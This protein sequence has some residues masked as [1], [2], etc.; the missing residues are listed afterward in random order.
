MAH[1][2]KENMK[3]RKIVYILGLFIFL[4]FLKIDFRITND[5]ICCNDDY[6]YFS[7][8]ETISKDFDFD[9]TNQLPDKSRYF[10]NNKNAQF[11]FVGA[12]LLSSPFMLIGSFFDKIFGIKSPMINLKHLMYSF[13]S[14]FYLIVSMGLL[15]K[16]SQFYKVKINYTLYLFGSGIIYYAFERYSMTSVYEVFTILLTIY[17]SVLFIKNSYDLRLISFLLPLSVLVALL[18]RWTNLFVILIPF[19]VIIKFNKEKPRLLKQL[20]NRYYFLSVAISIGLFSLLSKFIYGVVTFSPSYVYMVDEFDNLVQVNILQNFPTFIKDSVIDFI[21]IMFSQ[22]FGL[23]WF[24]PII[25][26]GTFLLIWKFVTNRDFE[27]LVSN[28]LLLICFAQNFFIVTIWNSTAS[29]YGFRYLFSLIPLSFLAIFI[30][31]EIVNSK[32][33]KNYL[34]VFSIFSILSVLFFETTIF[35]QLSLTPVMNSFGYEKVYSQPEYLTGLFK[36]FFVTESYLKIVATSF[37]G[38]LFLKL[39]IMLTSE[40]FVINLLSLTGYVNEDVVK[41]VSQLNEITGFYFVFLMILSS[42]STFFI[43]RHYSTSEI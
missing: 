8:A 7:H 11:G 25:F 40:I 12:G 36:S 23:F 32:L 2:V 34:K 4:I 42:I 1:K 39:S 38:A 19:I 27:S 28:G 9:Y 24:S 15:K 16:I 41:L 43:V 26:I 31:K 14:I 10:R 33:V 30:N 37:F 18:V 17:L 22:E 13:S 3:S 21:N 5:L 6:D 35:T 29:S 20:L